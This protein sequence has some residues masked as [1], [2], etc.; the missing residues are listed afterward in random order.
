[1]GTLQ[2]WALQTTIQMTTEFVEKHL[3]CFGSASTRLAFSGYQL[4]QHASYDKFCRA[5][6]P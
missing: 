2:K 4:W 6:L 1:M 5:H 3:Q